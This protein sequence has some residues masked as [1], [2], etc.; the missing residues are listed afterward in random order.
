MEKYIKGKYKND[1]FRSEKGYV[2]G[3]VKVIETNILELEDY[4]NHTITITGYFYDLNEKPPLNI[5]IYLRW[6]FKIMILM[7]PAYYFLQNSLFYR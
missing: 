6:F 3:I 1:I 4:I 5:L 2:I 7:Y